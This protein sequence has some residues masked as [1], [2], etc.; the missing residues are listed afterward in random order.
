MTVKA[1]WLG[2]LLLWR[3][4]KSAIAGRKQVTRFCSILNTITQNTADKDWPD[5][6]NSWLPLYYNKK[7]INQYRFYFWLDYPGFFGPKWG[8]G[9]PFGT[10]VLSIWVILNDHEFSPLIISPRKLE[11]SQIQLRCF[12]HTFTGLSY[13]SSINNFDTNFAHTF[14]IPKL[15]RYHFMHNSFC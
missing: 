9:M 10:L 5:D 8:R 12:W 2:K 6:K 11:S 14:F 13:C 7:K 3:F 15:S 4:Q 1:V